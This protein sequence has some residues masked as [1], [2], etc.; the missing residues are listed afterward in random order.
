VV[1]VVY[2]H[3]IFSRQ[4]TGGVSRYFA[5]LIRGVAAVAECRVAAGLHRNRHLAE[6]TTGVRGRY[7]GG[8]VAGLVAPAAR[9]LNRAWQE[10]EL[11]GRSDVVVH[12]TYFGFIPPARRGRTVVTVYDM[13]PELFGHASGSRVR[14]AG[15]KAA[16]R[17]SCRRADRVIAISETTKRD[18]CEHYGLDEAKVDAIPLGNSLDRFEGDR[19]DRPVAR[20]YLL[21][22]G[23]RGGYKNWAKLVEAVGSAASLRRD[24]DLVCFGGGPF[25]GDEL[26]LIGRAGLASRVHAARGDDEALA[27]HYRHAAAYVC[28]SLYEGFGLPCV[29]AMGLGCPVVC[30]DRGSLPE[31]VADAGIYFD[32]T[33]ADSIRDAVER[34][35][36]DRSA[37]ARLRPLMAEREKLFRWSRTVSAT[38]ETYRTVLGEMPRPMTEGTRKAA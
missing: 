1:S 33:D 14:L 4:A 38:L 36:S 6:V 27:A 7:F 25:T 12:Q 17:L 29:E 11:P 15:L 26:G 30:S 34:A 18:V 22:V 35:V 10:L 19:F 37:V 13:M 5:E 23:N 32:P 31:I 24:F 2:T 21:Y 28:P 3:D 20:P 8:R 16:K 9:L